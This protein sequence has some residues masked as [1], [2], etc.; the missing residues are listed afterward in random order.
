MSAAG[1]YGLTLAKAR[2]IIREVAAATSTW[3]SMASAVGA[4]P[5]EITRMASTFEH[6]DVARATVL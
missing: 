2:T 3:R 4:R 6:D 5:A 1:Y